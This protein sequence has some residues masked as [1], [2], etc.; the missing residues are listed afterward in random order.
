MQCLPWSLVVRKVALL[1]CKV[2]LS[3]L[4]T[5]WLDSLFFR[6]NETAIHWQYKGGRSCCLPHSLT[7]IR[8]TWRK[9]WHQAQHSNYY[10]LL[11]LYSAFT[12]SEDQTATPVGSEQETK[13]TFSLPLCDKILLKLILY[14]NYICYVSNQL[15]YVAFADDTNLFCSGKNLEMHLDTEEKELHL[16]KHWFSVNK[17]S[18]N[19][20]KTKHIIFGNCKVNNIKIDN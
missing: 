13:D 17:L 4:W 11:G 3:L 16:S 12:R 6:D 14:I 19:V 20:N 5:A 15:K 8:R 1:S 18:L 7:R 10:Y 2:K 9:P